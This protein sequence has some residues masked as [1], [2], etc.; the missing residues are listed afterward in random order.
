MIPVTPEDDRLARR[1]FESSDPAIGVGARHHTA[2]A[3]FLGRFADSDDH[4]VVRG[5]QTGRPRPPVTVSAETA[6]RV[7]TE[8]VR[9]PDK[10]YDL[11][12]SAPSLPDG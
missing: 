10:A 8:T 12:C 7:S 2:P 6:S 9:L 3:F 11:P 1:L 5:R 4:L